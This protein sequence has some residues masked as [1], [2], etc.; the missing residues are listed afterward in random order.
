MTFELDTD[1]VEYQIMN[2]K[3]L[4]FVIYVVECLNNNMNNST[5]SYPFILNYRFEVVALSIRN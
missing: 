5:E 1:C 4:V 3:N 2:I